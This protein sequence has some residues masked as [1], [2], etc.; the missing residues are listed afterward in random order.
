MLKRSN[1]TDVL[2]NEHKIGSPDCGIR[3]YDSKNCTISGN[4]MYEIHKLGIHTSGNQY[5]IFTNNTVIAELNYKWSHWGISVGGESCIVSQNNVALFDLYG[6][7]VQ[8]SGNVVERNNVTS[9]DSGLLI[10]GNMNIV[11]RNTFTNNIISIEVALA[12]E[13]EVF[14]NEICGE[15]NRSDTGIMIHGGHYCDIHSNNITHVGF[16]ITLQGANGFNISNNSI[17]ESRYGFAF[18]WNGYTHPGDSVFVPDGPADD[19]NITNNIFDRGGLFSS[20]PNYDMWNFNTIRFSG[21][22]VN[23][24]VIGFFAYQDDLWIYA[25]D[26]GQLFLVSCRFATIIGGPISGVCSDVGEGANHDPGQAAA[27][28]LINC[29]QAWLDG[30]SFHSNTIGVCLQYSDN[31][32]L[33][34]ATIYDHSWAA[35][36]LWYSNGFQVWDVDFRNNRKAITLGWSHGCD[37]NDCSIWY[38]EEGIYLVSSPSCIIRRNTIFQN[39]YAM[40]LAESDDCQIWENS[41]Y[42]NSRGILLNSSSD[43]FITRNNVYDNSG[44]GVC[45]DRFSNNNDI[46]DNTFIDNFPNAICEGSS[47]QWDDGF[48]TGNWWSDF[49]GIGVYVIDEND[50]DNYPINTITITPTETP[51]PTTPT[52]TFE[53]WVVDPFALV[54]ASGAVGLVLIWIIIIDRRR[55]GIID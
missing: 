25:E 55:V 36:I 15:L 54:I 6:I 47:N 2:N 35:A 26:Y 51:T 12:N 4:R 23:G 7:E 28:T 17:L 22:T 42:R 46:Y 8:G 32:K 41:I 9:N 27:I 24:K 48:N 44:V 30:I 39:N 20:I 31:C 50:M 43:C 38:N 16:G 21:N 40:I 1:F 13:T 29:F 37:I 34:W 3:V 14:E 45:L 49:F 33:S 11:R 52:T 5:S 18:N 10:I 19:C 53:P